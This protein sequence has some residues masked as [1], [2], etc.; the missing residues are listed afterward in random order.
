MIGDLILW[1]K[2]VWKQQ[3]C[4][5]SYRLIPDKTGGLGGYDLYKCEK[6]V[7]IK[8]ISQN[9]GKFNLYV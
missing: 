9:K 5:H 6:C 2:K 1:I 3:T 8:D 4:L 7:K